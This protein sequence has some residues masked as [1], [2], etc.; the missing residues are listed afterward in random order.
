MIFVQVFDIN[1]LSFP[2]E[3]TVHHIELYAVTIKFMV[4]L[5]I[6]YADIKLFYSFKVLEFKV[7]L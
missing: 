4:T 1:N 6:F 5:N 7:I 2:E 3:K